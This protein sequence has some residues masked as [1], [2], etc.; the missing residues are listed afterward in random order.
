MKKIIETIKN[1][2][3]IEDLRT[4]LLIAVEPPV[5]RAITFIADARRRKDRE[6][7]VHTEE[8]FARERRITIRRHRFV[9]NGCADVRNHGARPDL[10]TERGGMQEV[11]KDLTR[12]TSVRRQELIA[13]IAPEDVL[14]VRE[15][16]NLLVDE[17][18]T[19]AGAVRQVLAAR[20][21]R[22]EDDLR[23]RLFRADRLEDLTD[24]EDGVADRSVF[25]LEVSRVVRAD[26]HDRALRLVAVQ[27]AAFT[28][29]PQH[30]LGAVSEI[31]SLSTR[32]RRSSCL[33]R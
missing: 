4:P 10:V 13:E 17:V 32:K 15:L 12:E 6:I 20:E 2:W 7:P 5:R 24:P 9:T 21:D 26:H 1:I 23:L 8:L 29:P 33:R 14:A 27:L 31:R 22:A 11:G 25:A 30:V 19:H 18:V 16:H 3:R 28:D